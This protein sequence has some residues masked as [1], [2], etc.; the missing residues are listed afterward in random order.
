MPNMFNYC[1]VIL[2]K[3]S[4]DRSLFRKEYKKSLRLLSDDE[5]QALKLWIRN[6]RNLA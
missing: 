1:K 6:Q 5:A 2:S 4:F 3:V